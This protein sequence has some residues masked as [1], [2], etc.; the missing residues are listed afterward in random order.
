MWRYFKVNF[1]QT[2]DKSDD[3]CC[4]CESEL[5]NTDSVDTDGYVAFYKN[6]W[7]AVLM[8][9]IRSPNM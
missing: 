1:V 6:E 5:D 4:L 7:E 3:V 9:K 8:Q 2:V